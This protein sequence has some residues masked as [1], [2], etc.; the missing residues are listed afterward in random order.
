MT[1]NYY[2]WLG[3]WIEKPDDKNFKL[4]EGSGGSNAYEVNISFVVPELPYNPIGYPLTFYNPRLN[5][6]GP[7]FTFLLKI[8][9]SLQISPATAVPGNQASIQG[10]GFPANTVIALTLDGKALNTAVKTNDKGSFSATS[11]IPVTIGGN[12]EFKAAV[13]DTYN[14]E[15]KATFKLVPV[16]T[17]APDSPP[18]GSNATISGRGF[19]GRNEVSIEYD[20]TAISNLPTTDDSGSFSYTFKVPQASK[21]EHSVNAT[22]KAGNRAVLGGV[23][24]EVEAPPAPAPVKPTAQTFGWFGASVV[25]FAWTDVSDPSG[26][27]YILEIGDNLSFFP[28]GPG[29]RKTGLTTTSAMVNLKPGTYYWRVKAVDGAGNESPWTL[30]PYPFKVGVISITYLILGAIIL[31]LVIVFA[32][33]AAFRRIH[34]YY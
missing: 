23:R 5:A 30:S 20:G 32:I 10:N 6:E 34:E 21:S 15:A 8:E 14:L 19:A 18:V 3:F 25:S 11:T 7:A 29:M 1:G 17:M 13:P 2:L 26:V 27:S 12:H 9:P 28:L 16:I 24:L 22:D 33:R 4:A 31:V